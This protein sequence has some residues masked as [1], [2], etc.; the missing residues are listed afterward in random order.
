MSQPPPA[1][2]SIHQLHPDFRTRLKKA[3][4]ESVATCADESL[5]S[6][7]A[8]TSASMPYL[9]TTQNCQKLRLG[10]LPLVHLWRA[11]IL[12][13]GG[14][15][16]RSQQ[17]GAPA[18]PLIIRGPY[19][20]GVHSYC[21]RCQLLPGSESCRFV[22]RVATTRSG[23]RCIPTGKTLNDPLPS[24]LKMRSIHMRFQYNC[25]ERYID[26]VFLKRHFSKKQ[27]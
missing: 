17:A 25:V 12:T 8:S 3:K 15:Y 2:Y 24:K 23:E 5:A 9:Q 11:C 6:P 18:P 16:L 22:G 1:R 19:G 10:L 13:G 21:A 7:R 20:D 14:G 26:M 4:K 27:R